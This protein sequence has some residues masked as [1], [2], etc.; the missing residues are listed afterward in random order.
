MFAI[1][2]LMSRLCLI[3]SDSARSIYG[4]DS[5]HDES[6]LGFEAGTLG[7]VLGARGPEENGGGQVAVHGVAGVGAGVGLIEEGGGAVE[8]ILC[9]VHDI[10]YMH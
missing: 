1:A 9:V 10:L 5:G 6:L 8:E 3:Q 7:L 2:L 4:K